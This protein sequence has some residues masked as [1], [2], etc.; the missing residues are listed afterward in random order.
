MLGW[1]L[2]LGFAGGGGEP[3]VVFP[4]II[5]IDSVSAVVPEA[6]ASAILPQAT[7]SAVIPEADFTAIVLNPARQ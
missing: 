1:L 2:N 5:G 6:S 4:G 7:V 3:T